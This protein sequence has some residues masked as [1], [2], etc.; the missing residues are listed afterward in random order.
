MPC[1]CTD[2]KCRDVQ[3]PSEL[4]RWDLP[5]SHLHCSKS[6]LWQMG[7][8]KHLP[9]RQPRTSSVLDCLNGWFSSSTQFYTA[10]DRLRNLI[11]SPVQLGLFSSLAQSPPFCDQLNG[12]ISWSATFCS[13]VN[14]LNWLFPSLTEFY[15]FLD[16][17]NGLFSFLVQFHSFLGSSLAQFYLFW[18][19]QTVCFSLSF[20]TF[21]DCLNGLFCV[22][23]SSTLFLI[24]QWL[25]FVFSSVS[26]FLINSKGLFP[27]FVQF[28]L[29]L[30]FGMV[31]FLL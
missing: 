16:C 20:Q 24:V 30:I 28:C 25:V 1:S 18:S 2:L 8:S 31:F 22:W 27:P 10:L 4:K 6:E 11:S 29:F 21:L 7:I 23:R 9:L 13:F 15:T 3:S 26:P 19:I 12:L 17:W 14:C 5:F